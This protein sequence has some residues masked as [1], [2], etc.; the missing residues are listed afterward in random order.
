M[1][2]GKQVI[3]LAVYTKDQRVKLAVG[4]IDRAVSVFSIEPDVASPE[5]GAAPLEIATSQ[6]TG[7]NFDLEDIEPALLSFQRDGRELLI[8]GTFDGCMYVAN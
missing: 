2:G 4:T 1:A 3:S 6:V 5:A 7:T 8:L